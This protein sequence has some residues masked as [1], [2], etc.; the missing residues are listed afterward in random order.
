M[1]YVD[2]PMSIPGSKFDGYCHL[3]ND[4]PFQDL[5]DFARQLGLRPEWLQH[6]SALGGTWHFDISPTKRALAVK[7]GAT[8]IATR[9]WIAQQQ[10]K[11]ASE[12]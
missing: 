8:E 11:K 7:K 6:S 10:S 1:I 3:L 5:M 4:G 9:D 12:T 2:D